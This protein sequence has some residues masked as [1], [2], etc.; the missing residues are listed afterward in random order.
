M[1]AEQPSFDA[2]IPG[3]SLTHELGARPWQS[4]AQFS[5]VEEVVEYYLERMSLED[6]SDQLIDVMEMGVP[7]TDIANTLQLGG[8]M[9][10]VHSIDTGI[11]VIPLLI[12]MMMLIG[13]SAGVKYDSGLESNP[14][15]DKMRKSKADKILR[16]LE[17]KIDEK[18]DTPKKEMIEDKPEMDMPTG[19]MARRN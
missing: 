13:D 17:L 8:V 2:P 6:F 18:E 9:E 5:N 7:V 11:L 1:K 19:L 14:N 15:K 3:M 16:K 12:E 10:G 4:P